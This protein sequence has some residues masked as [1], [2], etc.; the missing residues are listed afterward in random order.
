M[1]SVKKKQSLSLII[2]LIVASFL[3]AGCVSLSY[4]VATGQRETILYPTEKEVKLGKRLAKKLID[5]YGLVDDDIEQQRIDEIGKRLARVSDRQDIEYHFDIIDDEEVNALA[6]PGGYIFISKG[7]VEVA[8]TDDEI[9]AVLAHEV[10]HVACYHAVK[11]MQGHFLYTFLRALSLTQ[12][13][14]PAFS[15]GSDFAYLSVMMRYSQDYE[16]EADRLSARYLKRA[17]FNPEAALSIL[18]KLEEIDKK[19]PL[20][21]HTYFRTHPPIATRKAVIRQ[22]I[23][24]RL[25]YEGYLN[26]MEDY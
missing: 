21:R 11:K 10:G 19:K 15:A 6:L 14:D 2:L 16:K 1:K 26:L 23:T 24:G 4:N 25:D 3:M 7:L 12:E 18:D 9:A 13:R 22:E 20:R 8:D 17:G 5:K